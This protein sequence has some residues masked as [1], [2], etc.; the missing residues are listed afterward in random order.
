MCPTMSEIKVIL[1][2]NKV[3]HFGLDI[4]NQSQILLNFSIT[5]DKIITNPLVSH[6]LNAAK[7]AKAPKNWKS[8]EAPNITEWFSYVEDIKQ[9]EEITHR[10]QNKSNLFWETWSLWINDMMT[11]IVM[12]VLHA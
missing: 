11:V 12:K 1:I 4:N 7:A 8:L 9:M 6:L 2:I 5:N 3:S 10:I